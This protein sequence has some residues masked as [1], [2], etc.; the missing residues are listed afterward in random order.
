V[1]DAERIDVALY[2]AVATTP[3]PALDKAVRR[4]TTAANYSRLSL[5]AA[6]A[7]GRRPQAAR[8][9]GGAHG[10]CLDRGHQHDRQR[11]DQAVGASPAPG[12]RHTRRAAE[13]PRTDAEVAIIP[14]RSHGQRVR[15]SRGASGKIG[16]AHVPRGMISTMDR[17]DLNAYL[18]RVLV[19][20]R[21]PVSAIA[22]ADYNPAWPARFETERARIGQGSATARS[23]SSTSAR[24][25]VPGS[26]PRRSSTFS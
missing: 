17:H 15:A 24:P 26:L 5:A 3:T 14:V 10:P 1:R 13:P 9:T 6:A 21:E 19:G 25:A 8:A 23:E 12:P 16:L 2:A 4:L 22:I 7:P 11:R 18:D 20:G